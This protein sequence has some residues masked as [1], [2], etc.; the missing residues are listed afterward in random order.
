MKRLI[1]T[2]VTFVVAA[3][4]SALAQVSSTVSLAEVARQ[5]EARRKTTKKA[6]KVFTNSNLGTP[7]AASAGSSTTSGGSTPVTQPT[8]ALGE[9]PAAPPAPEKTQ[10]FW[11]KR[12]SAAREALTRAQT[13]ADAMQTKINSLQN[14]IPNL[15]YPAR[16]LA[17]KQLNAALAE[18]ERLKKEVASHQKAI[19]GIEEEARRSNVPVGWLRPGA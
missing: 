4:S 8:I 16:G 19:T 13:F 11:Q 3:S 5:E 18:L 12:I 14:D 6:T 15:D 17:E 2:A 10:E 1:A 7:D 9:E